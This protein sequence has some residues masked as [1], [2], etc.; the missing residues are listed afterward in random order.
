MGHLLTSG[1]RTHSP[2]SSPCSSVET[3]LHEDV[4]LVPGLAQWGGDGH[5]HELWCRSQMRLGSH[6]VVAV[7]RLA[8]IALIRTLAQE[9]SYAT[10]MALLKQTNKQ[11]KKH[12]AQHAQTTDT[13]QSSLEV[14]MAVA[15]KTGTTHCDLHSEHNYKYLEDRRNSYLLILSYFYI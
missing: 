12:T 6:V 7:Y 1:S 8:A 13:R 9:L 5:C 10:G 15:I 14:N 11:T 3:N 4:H 2:G